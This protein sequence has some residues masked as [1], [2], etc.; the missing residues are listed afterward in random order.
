MGKDEMVEGDEADD[1]TLDP[2][3][4]MSPTPPTPP[5]HPA[6]P[7]TIFFHAFLTSCALPR[8]RWAGRVDV[9]LCLLASSSSS[10]F[11]C[12]L[13]LLPLGGKLDFLELVEEAKQV[14]VRH[15]AARGW[16]SACVGVWHVRVWEACGLEARGKEEAFRE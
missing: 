15:G 2:S 13:P 9:L 8:G 12:P 7:G 11:P 3:H 16:V 6:S 14:V 10:S 1:L 4:S 5:S